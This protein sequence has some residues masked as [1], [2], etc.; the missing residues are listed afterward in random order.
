[1]AYNPPVIDASGQTYTQLRN[2]GFTGHVRA[3]V[4]GLTTNPASQAAKVRV[5]LLLSTNAHEPIERARYLID[6]YL[7]GQTDK[8]STL[9]ALYD[10]HLATASLA[11]S[12]GEVAALID[13]N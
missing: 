11:A 7:N 1:V 4:G 5:D 10:L 8:A 9:A 6:G 13:A 3:L 12:L 2:H